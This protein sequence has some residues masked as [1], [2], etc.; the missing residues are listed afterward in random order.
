[1]GVIW[2]CKELDTAWCNGQRDQIA[3]NFEEVFWA[4]MALRHDADL[5]GDFMK[6]C[7]QHGYKFQNGPRQENAV[8]EAAFVGFSGD[9]SKEAR[10]RASGFARAAAFL[11]RQR[12]TPDSFREAVQSAGSYRGLAA[13]SAKS[14]REAKSGD[15]GVLVGA[16][17]ANPVSSACEQVVPASAEGSSPRSSGRIG[18]S[19][20]PAEREN[21]VLEV[22]LTPELARRMPAT[23]YVMIV[24]RRTDGATR[25][26]AVEVYAHTA[27]D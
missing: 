20:Q 24:A 13:K 4:G 25:L 23:D 2:R 18:R 27:R 15:K 9:R 8:W 10:Q 21:L 26:E 16:T 19:F 3:I 22:E 11:A 7:D 1:V 5:Y 6:R 17:A 14:R 12:I